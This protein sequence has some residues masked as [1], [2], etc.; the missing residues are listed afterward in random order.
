MQAQLFRSGLDTKLRQLLDEEI[1]CPFAPFG[2]MSGVLL[3]VLHYQR[4]LNLSKM[5]SALHTQPQFMVFHPLISVAVAEP[6]ILEQGASENG[7]RLLYWIIIE[8]LRFDVLSF[9]REL[10]HLFV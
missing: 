3:F 6:R 1:E 8:P 7:R 9:L 10:K 5:G 4:R 2:I